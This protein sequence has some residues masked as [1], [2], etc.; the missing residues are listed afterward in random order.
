MSISGTGQVTSS[1]RGKS[2][3]RLG[4]CVFCS[5]TTGDALG[6]RSFISLVPPGPLGVPGPMMRQMI[7]I[8]V[9]DW[10]L[11]VLT[12]ISS[13]NK[14]ITGTHVVSQKLIECF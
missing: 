6:G 12:A 13:S 11:F 4:L 10:L 14:L 9:V 2:H 8:K 7:G 1:A 3:L 5:I